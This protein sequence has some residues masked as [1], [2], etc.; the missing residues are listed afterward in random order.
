MKR[1]EWAR[2]CLQ[3]LGCPDDMLDH[4]LDRL[5]IGDEPWTTPDDD[6]SGGMMRH[7]ERAAIRLRVEEYGS[8]VE[9]ARPGYR[10]PDPRER[11]TR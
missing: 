1:H 9:A 4:H 11:P 3:D 7:D 2:L 10:F 5:G 6:A 8:V